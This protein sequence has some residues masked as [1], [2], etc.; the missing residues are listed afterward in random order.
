[1]N[2][3]LTVGVLRQLDERVARLNI[4]RQGVIKTLL[5][6]ALGEERSRRP[7]PNAARER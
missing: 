3:D 6:Q 1:M 2:V 7:R 4:S 5:G